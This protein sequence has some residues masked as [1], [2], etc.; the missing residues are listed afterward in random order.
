MRTD[1]EKYGRGRSL[2]MIPRS[3]WNG[4]ASRKTKKK[5]LEACLRVR[6]RKRMN[7]EVVER[8]KTNKRESKKKKSSAELGWV[9]VWTR[10]KI[11]KLG[12]E[13]AVSRGMRSCTAGKGVSRK[14]SPSKKG[15]TSNRYVGGRLDYKSGWD[16]DSAKGSSTSGIRPGK[17]SKNVSGTKT[18]AR[19]AIGEK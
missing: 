12:G 10:W 2:I 14:L 17:R 19:S 16:G 13:G 18:V 1:K 5:S 9:G 15:G 8:G 3:L 6:R 4:S 11:E 7:M